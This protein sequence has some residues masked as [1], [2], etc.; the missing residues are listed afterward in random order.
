M[1]KQQSEHKFPEEE[2]RF[3][4]IVLEAAWAEVENTFRS[5]DEAAP[6]PG[7]TARFM[8]RLELERQRVEKRQAMALIITNLV[9]AL[10]FIILISLQFIPSISSQGL[11]SLWVDMISRAVIYI[12]MISGLL[13]TFAR[14]FPRIVPTSWVVSG[15]T[16]VGILVAVWISLA[17]RHLRKQGVRNVEK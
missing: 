6:L 1:S 2:I 7:F 4:D 9:I 12:K 8:D 5:A 3:E 15:F 14:T 13:G 10:G 16:L 17:R 11:L